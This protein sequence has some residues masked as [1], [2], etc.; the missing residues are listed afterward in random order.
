M[1]I[2]QNLN[3]PINQPSPFQPGNNQWSTRGQHPGFHQDRTQDGERAAR[4][5]CS[6]EE[7]GWWRWC[8]CIMLGVFLRVRL[9]GGVGVEDF[10][11][12]HISPSLSRQSARKFHSKRKIEWE[13]AGPRALAA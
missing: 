8:V 5:G 11:S 10:L 3:L 13:R 4:R 6:A 12:S 2:T 7:K 1:S 9:H